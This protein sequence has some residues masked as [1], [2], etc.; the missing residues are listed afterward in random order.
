MTWPLGARSLSKAA[1]KLLMVEEMREH[2][3]AGAACNRGR[4]GR[5]LSAGRCFSAHPPLS[6][7]I[8]LQGRTL[9]HVTRRCAL[10]SYQH[11]SALVTSY[12]CFVPCSIL[13]FWP[14]LGASG[15]SSLRQANSSTKMW[16]PTRPG[17]GSGK[18]PPLLP[19]EQTFSS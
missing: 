13:P 19:P 6:S 10:F 5:G 1:C 17:G 15:T 8:L 7:R 2:L 11:D 9:L 16:E 4:L 3:G 14:K 18:Q 12:S